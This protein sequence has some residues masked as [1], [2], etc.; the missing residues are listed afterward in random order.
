MKYSSIG[1]I[2][3]RVQQARHSPHCSSHSVPS[4][5]AAHRYDEGGIDS[6]IGDSGGPLFTVMDGEVHHLLVDSLAVEA[7]HSPWLGGR[8]IH[9]SGAL[10]PIFCSPPV[11]FPPSANAI[12]D[13]EP[14]ANPLFVHASRFSRARS[15]CVGCDSGSDELGGGLCGSVSAWRVHSSSG[16]RS[17]PACVCAYMCV[18]V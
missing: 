7:L 10:R 3:T 6:C 9:D 12:S 17:S 15:W 4:T 14:L 11:A 18:R 16:K 2:G 1:T 5:H 8:R 13:P